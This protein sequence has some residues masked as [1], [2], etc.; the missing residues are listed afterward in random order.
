VHGS[1]GRAKL[2]DGPPAGLGLK[3]SPLP[4]QAVGP[5]QASEG[6]GKPDLYRSLVGCGAWATV[7]RNPSSG[8]NRSAGP[9][10]A[11]RHFRPLQPVN[12]GG[13]DVML[14]SAAYYLKN[15]L[16]PFYFKI[17]ENAFNL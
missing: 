8:G 3:P 16:F 10:T 6:G 14:T 15:P 13:A 11:Q 12:P 7:G 5:D 9:P 2:G 1:P 17:P 4:Q